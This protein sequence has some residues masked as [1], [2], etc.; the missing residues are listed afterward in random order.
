MKSL[1]AELDAYQY[2]ILQGEHFHAISCMTELLTE[3][4]LGLSDSL[5]R[6]SIVAQCREHPIFETLKL[7]P[8][9]LRAFEKP[10]GYPG[11]AV[12]LDYAYYLATPPGTGEVGGHIFEV[13]TGSPNALSVRWRRQHIADLLEQVAADRVSLDV[14]SVACGHCREL[15]LLSVPARSKIKRFVALDHDGGALQRAADANKDVDVATWQCDVKNLPAEDAHSGFDFIYSIG[16]YDYLQRDQAEKLT[17]WLLAKLNPGGQLLIANFTPDNWGRGYMEA[18]M[19]WNLILRSR[20]QM[21][22]LEPSEWLGHSCLYF[23]PYR[24]INFMLLRKPA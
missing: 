10:R 15:E 12:M 14:L 17:R 18:F 3:C 21:R 19:D 2:G 5:W 9:T 20:E 13:V 4:R 1:A 22:R 11:D 6:A 23:D 8:Y 7:D 16:I 24:N